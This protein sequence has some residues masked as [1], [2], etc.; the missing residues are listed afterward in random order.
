MAKQFNVSLGF[1]ADTSQAKSAIQSLVSA[2]HKLRSVGIPVGNHRARQITSD[3]FREFD[4]IIGM[5]YA[6]K[7]NL[8]RM[9]PPGCN[10]PIN[11]LLEFAGIDAD[12]ADPWYTGNFDATYIDVLKGCTAL[13]E[14]LMYM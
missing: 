8:L 11:L 6:N 10:V 3:D 5:D 4:Y 13:L 14:K 1:T 9:V 2:L 7:R 12:I